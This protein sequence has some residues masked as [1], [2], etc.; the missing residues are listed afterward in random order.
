[1][2]SAR[3]VTRSICLAVL[4]TLFLQ[5]AAGATESR[6]VT[7][8]VLRLS[9]GA[10]EALTRSE[11]LFHS[12]LVEAGAAPPQIDL[13]WKGLILRRGD[14]QAGVPVDLSLQL[15]PAFGARAG[16]VVVTALESV[17][18]ELVVHSASGPERWTLAPGNFGDQS[19]R[20]NFGSADGTLHLVL[21][22][23]LENAQGT[24]V[25]VTIVAVCAR[26]AEHWS[27]SRAS[28]IF[29]EMRRQAQPNAGIDAVLSSWAPQ[30][31]RDENGKD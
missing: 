21:P 6:A 19:A 10:L 8:G 11:V 13:D 25:G 4:T 22:V 23:L 12:D 1:M 16:A 14:L 28:I 7:S 26:S 5:T 31:A 3:R 15:I 9:G 20:I 17:A 30:P 18:G 29:E 24:I 2:R 27:C